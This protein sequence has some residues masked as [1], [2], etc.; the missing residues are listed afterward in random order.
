MNTVTPRLFV[1]ATRQNDGKTTVCLG[2]HAALRSRF[3][4]IGFIKPVGQRFVQL[5][6]R[7]IDEDSVLIHETYDPQIPL[8]DMSPIA[9]E[10]DFT[11]RYINHANHDFLVRRLRHSFD[12]ACWEKDCVLIEGTG[13]AG[14]G[15]V[16]D[17]SNARVA[18]LLESPA[19]LVTG[20]GIGRPVDEVALNR[21]LFD[22]EGVRLAGVILNKVLPAKLDTVRDFVGRA[23]ARAGI[24]L[25]GVIPEEPVLAAPTL[26]QVREELRGSFLHGA[27]GE[28]RP[29]GRVLIAAMSTA[30]LLPH[31]T[32]QCLVITPGDREDIILAALSRS[33]DPGGGPALAGVVL[34]GNLE[35]PSPILAGIRRSDLPFIQCAMDSYT[36]ASRLHS[37]TVKTLPGDR[38]RIRCIQELVEQHVAVDLVA[39]IIRR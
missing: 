3:A 32:P 9:I 16:F 5:E 4:R 6:G 7:K 24:P 37:M 31:L 23:L 19:I 21:A 22:R 33:G 20:G 1:A 35:P 26:G 8:E 39:D 30:N 29:V 25:L 2:L 15:S 38:A 18:R 12:R 11:R 13:H 34:S 28:R 10:P 27:E 17:L 36:V 14:V